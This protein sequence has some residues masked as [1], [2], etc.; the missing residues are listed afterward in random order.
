[1]NGTRHDNRRNGVLEDQLLLIIGFQND[2]VLIEALDPS[3]Q[4]DPAHQ[5]YGEEDPLLAGTVEKSFLN[6]LG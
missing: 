2:G 3:R 1:M 5:I 6:V 4:F